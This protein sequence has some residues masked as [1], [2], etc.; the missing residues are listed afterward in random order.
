MLSIEDVKN[1]EKKSLLIEK[2]NVPMN[3]VYLIL[4]IIQR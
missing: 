4:R 1:L 3:Q 2:M